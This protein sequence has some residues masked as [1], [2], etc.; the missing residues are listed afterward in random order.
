MRALMIATSIALIAGSAAASECRFV[1]IE[2]PDFS[3][4]FD[5][6]RN[7]VLN[8]AGKIERYDSGTA[9]TGMSRR[10]AY[11][12]DGIDARAEAFEIHEFDGHTFLTWGADLLVKRCR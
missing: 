6:R 11:P 9:G 1:D 12:R 10:V 4:T 5:E 7:P 2:H 8:I 3:I